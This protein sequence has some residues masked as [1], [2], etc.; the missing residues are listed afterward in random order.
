MEEEADSILHRGSGEE[1]LKC[2]ESGMKKI[3]QFW[4]VLQNM[5][6]VRW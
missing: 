3:Y 2:F 5:Q 6:Q 4:G 1:Y